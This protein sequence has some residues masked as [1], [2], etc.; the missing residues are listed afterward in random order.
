MNVIAPECYMPTLFLYHLTTSLLY[1]YITP[2]HPQF[3]P[4]SPHLIS[5]LSLHHPTSAYPIS[6]LHILCHMYTYNQILRQVHSSL[7]EH[8][9]SVQDI[10]LVPHLQPPDVSMVAGS[11]TLRQT[12]LKSSLM[13]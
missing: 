4:T 5:T 1:P 10:R 2:P 3:I 6:Y 13:M 11:G 9:H 12:V 8:R 7:G